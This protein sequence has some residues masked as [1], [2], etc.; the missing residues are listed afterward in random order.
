[1]LV[2]TSPRILLLCKTSQ[3]NSNHTWTRRQARSSGRG[4]PN[5]P[6]GR[7]HCDDYSR[8]RSAS[9]ACTDRYTLGATSA[10]A[11]CD[12]TPTTDCDAQATTD[13]DTVY[14]TNPSTDE[15]AQAAA[16]GNPGVASAHLGAP[17]GANGRDAA[18]AAAP[19]PGPGARWGEGGGNDQ[20]RLATYTDDRAHRPRIKN[21]FPAAM[22]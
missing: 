19:G 5:Q 17:V 18:L 1:V 16:S 10:A 22:P 2:L 14:A 12:A 20:Q 3:Q 4:D 21:G 9:D 15:H 13:G 6:H 11:T 7:P 8:A